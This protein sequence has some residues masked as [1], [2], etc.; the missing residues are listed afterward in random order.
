MTTINYT[1]AATDPT[2]DEAFERALAHAREGRAAPLEHLIAGERHAAG[3]LF[4]RNDPCDPA[5]VVARAHAATPEIV[6]AA[7]RAARAAKADWAATPLAERTA[8]LRRI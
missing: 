1:S 2:L 3:E 4:E 5:R 6:A 7:V 8:A